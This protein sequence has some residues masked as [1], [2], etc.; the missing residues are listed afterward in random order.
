MIPDVC[1]LMRRDHDDLDRGLIAMADPTTP[2]EEMSSLVDILKLA[3]AV[4]VA[5]EAKVFE[6]LVAALPGPLPL[7]LVDAQTRDDH[8]RQTQALDALALARPGSDAWFACALELRVLVLE[9]TQRVELIRWVLQDHVPLGMHRKLA[10][11]YATE[12]MRVLAR[13][14]PVTLAREHLES[15]LAAAG[16]A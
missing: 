8:A 15:R 7:R 2:I 6:S 16:S 9:H 11:D 1:E 10:S 13:T 3:L 14:S 5:A 12:R 4:H